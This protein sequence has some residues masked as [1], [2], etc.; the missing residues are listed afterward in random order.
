MSEEETVS[1]DGEEEEEKEE[2]EWK[3]EISRRYGKLPFAIRDK[4]WLH[5]QLERKEKKIREL[6][7]TIDFLTIS[8][9]ET[10][11]SLSSSGGS[12]IATKKR[13]QYLSNLEE[14]EK[15][16]RKKLKTIELLDYGDCENDSPYFADLMTIPECFNYVF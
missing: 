1:Y 8:P 2:T 15:Y 9:I 10:S 16:S 12:G 13:R 14:T 5:E 6:Q 11:S 3:K 4:L 7:R